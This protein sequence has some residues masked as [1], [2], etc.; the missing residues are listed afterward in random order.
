MLL[1]LLI[2]GLANGGVYGLVA[3]GLV[4]LHRS[5]GVMN[6]AHGEMALFVTFLSFFLVQLG[7]PLSGAFLAALLAAA[8]L[9]WLVERLLLRPFAGSS[10]LSLVI[11][12][13]GLLMALNGL[14]SG[15]WG[16]LPQRFPP[17]LAGPPVRLASWPVQRQDLLI[18]GVLVFSALVLFGFLFFTKFGLASRAAVQNPWMAR[19]L[20][21]SI[22][23]VYGASW[24]LSAALAALASILFAPKTVLTTSMMMSVLI[25]GFTAGVLGGFNS[26]PGAILGGVCLGVMENLMA[27][28]VST[29]WKDSLA[30]ALIV[31][32]LLVRPE[33][34]LG[35]KETQ[36]V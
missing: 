18:L 6:F 36:R 3:L 16:T 9:G 30:L 28:Y 14:S 13:M 7:W 5:Y 4:W 27:F 11:A 20:G 10:P 12:T 23:K 1:P 17:A 33:G 25:K 31:L 26:L 2:G 21:V 29:Q 22:N 8:L 32:V 35:K 15:I 24:A 34:L 19:L